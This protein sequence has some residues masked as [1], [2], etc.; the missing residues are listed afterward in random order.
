MEL[1]TRALP[2]NKHKAGLALRT[3]RNALCQMLPFDAAQ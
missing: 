2:E 1:A 3:G